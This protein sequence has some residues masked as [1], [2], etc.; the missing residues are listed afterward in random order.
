[1]DE[2]ASAEPAA[3][4]PAQELT[5]DVAHW[6]ARVRAQLRRVA[7][8]WV[9]EVTAGWERFAAHRLVR[10][11]IHGAY[12]AG[13]SSLLKRFLVED[14][15]PVPS[16][17]AIGAKPTSASIEQVDSGGVTWVD[18]P[19]T[20][21][22]NSQHEQLAEQALTL[23][24]ALVVVLSPQLLSGDPRYVIGLVNGSFHNPV[25]GRPLF[26]S[27]AL[28]VV[29]AQMDTAGVSAEDDIDGYYDLIE[30]KRAELLAALERNA[31]DLSAE[32]VHFVAADPDQAGPTA[33]PTP[34]DY[35]GHEKWDGIAELRAAVLDLTPRHAEL[36]NAA[37][38]RYWSWIGTQAHTRATEELQRLDDVLDAAG[39]QQRAID[40]QL[41]ELRGIDDT[42][43]SRLREMIYVQLTAIKVPAGDADSQRSHVEQQLTSTIDTWLVEWGGKLDQLARNAAT[44]QRVRAQGPGAAALHSY[45]DEVLADLASAE[46]T[47]PDLKPLF[48][49]F[50]AHAKTVARAGYKLFQGMSVEDARAELAHVRYLDAQS[51]EKY[52]RGSEGVLT[53]GEHSA[54]VRKSLSQLQVFEELLPVVVEFGG[55]LV[56]GYLETRAEQRRIELRAQLRRQADHI[57]KHVLEGG[58]DVQAWADAVSAFRASLEAARGSTELPEH[59]QRKEVLTEVTADLTELL[60]RPGRL[61]AHETADL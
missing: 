33:Q 37:A 24:D 21:A 2:T 42:A 20:G 47:G 10:V 23:T 39:R 8:D 25:A 27:G 52:F 26:P 54:Q 31:A 29:V 16:W 49:R 59:G 11:T 12:D 13:K 18:S 38:V 9:D 51:L 1:M 60:S 22:G 50:D 35:A 5:T 53:S 19:G 32:A 30:R 55:F 17:L 3:V 44:D 14:G 46:T 57:A 7:E 4:V 48:D 40:L 43:R 56:G 61:P 58:N 15:T 41:A 6:V 34:D 28:I 36:R 45:L